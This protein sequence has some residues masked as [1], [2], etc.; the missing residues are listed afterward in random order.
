MNSSHQSTLDAI[1]S[2]ERRPPLKIKFVGNEISPSRVTIKELTELLKNL[3]KGLMEIAEANA[4]EGAPT[5]SG[6][7]LER[8]EG[9]SLCA[10]IDDPTVPGLV[11]SLAVWTAERLRNSQST[12][13]ATNDTFTNALLEFNYR[14]GCRTQIFRKDSDTD[15]LLEFTGAAELPKSELIEE[16]TT[17]FGVLERVGGAEPK[18]I[19][20]LDS[21]ERIGC[22]LPGD[23]GF[24]QRL[25]K[26]LYLEVGISGRAVYNQ[27]TGEIVK[28]FA[29]ELTYTQTK[30]TVAFAE[31]EKAMG[32]YWADVD[33]M[34]L[35]REERGDYGE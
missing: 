9:G 21:G 7:C 11:N 31:L 18:A 24:A 6:L 34:A 23:L 22:T 19:L 1:E 17:W 13:S 33:V 25:A 28:L 10:V 27:A 4:Q 5:L 16:T 15:Y 8:L 2:I 32:R 3:N 26:Y 14:H 30:E 20:R 12:I 35:V 29:E